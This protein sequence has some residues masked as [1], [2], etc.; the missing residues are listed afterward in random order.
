MKQ[1]TTKLLPAIVLAGT[2]AFGENLKLRLTRPFTEAVIRNPQSLALYQGAEQAFKKTVT[3][4]TLVGA[5]NTTDKFFE[6]SKTSAATFTAIKKGGELS[7]KLGIASGF[8]KGTL[9]PEEKDAGREESF[10]ANQNVQEIQVDSPITDKFNKISRRADKVAFE[11]T[12]DFNNI[13]HVVR[14]AISPTDPSN[15]DPSSAISKLNMHQI[16]YLG[17]ALAAT[18]AV[19]SQAP[20][21]YAKEAAI[22]A[23][24]GA[25]SAAQLFVATLPK[26]IVSALFAMGETTTRLAVSTTIGTV[27]PIVKSSFGNPE[28]SD[29]DRISDVK[30]IPSNESTTDKTQI[31]DLVPQALKDELTKTGIRHEQVDG[32]K[33]V[34]STSTSVTQSN[35]DNK[36]RRL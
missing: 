24:A 35:L 23:L 17:G 2:A 32:Q 22:N 20:E 28:A 9:G 31:A 10:E 16:G 3:N 5:I 33:A 18:S 15:H 11:I 4:P 13:F 19:I 14:D 29:A 30:Y 36:K 12:N 27:V 7:T 6:L 8:I 21:G 25:I 26:H 34:V 1:T